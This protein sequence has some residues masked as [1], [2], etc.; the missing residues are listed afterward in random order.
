MLALHPQLT[1]PVTV[2]HQSSL[3]TQANSVPTRPFPTPRSTTT[4]A[5]S[6]TVSALSNH[7]SP[8]SKRRHPPSA[9][10]VS[11]PPSSAASQS[12]ADLDSYPSNDLLKLLAQLLQRI[13]TSNDKVFHA[14]NPPA[15][16]GHARSYSFD[17]PA[18]LASPGIKLPPPDKSKYP[19]YTSLTTASRSS[20]ASP[21]SPLFFHA[22]NVPTISVESY[23]L[24]ILKYCPTTNEVFL[25]LLVYFDRMA[26]LGK[27]IRREWDSQP[28]P[29]VTNDKVD[30]EEEK[31]EEQAPVTPSPLVIDSYNIHRLIIAGVTVASKFFS[32]VFYTNSRYAKVYS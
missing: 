9:I 20:I 21:T 5:T 10:A 13:A 23:L 15:S 3:P 29:D 1:T 2:H 7:T 17:D 27:G 14:N 31:G 32:D 16:T 12:Q 19:L 26:A 24:R 4:G 6:R 30:S 25:S 28:K 8:P 11:A 22:R 18:P